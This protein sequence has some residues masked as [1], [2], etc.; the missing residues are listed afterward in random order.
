MYE[1]LKSVQPRLCSLEPGL[2]AIQSG[3]T[4]LRIPDAIEITTLA[5]ITDGALSCTPRLSPSA[6]IGQRPSDVRRHSG[7]HATLSL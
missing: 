3:Q 1:L 7:D 4:F 2:D 6:L 5:M